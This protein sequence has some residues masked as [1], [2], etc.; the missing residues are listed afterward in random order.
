MSPGNSGTSSAPAAEVQTAK[1]DP[2]MAENNNTVN[3]ATFWHNALAGQGTM[4]RFPDN[5]T[6]RMPP[7]IG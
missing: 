2:Y 1:V 5:G 3:A 7:P 6:P 4:M